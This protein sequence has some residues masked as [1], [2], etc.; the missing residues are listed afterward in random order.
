MGCDEHA[1]M[2][3]GERHWNIVRFGELHGAAEHNGGQ[4]IGVAAGW[5][6]VIRRQPGGDLHVDSD[7]GGAGRAANPGWRAVVAA[8]GRYVR[9]G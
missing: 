1:G 6:A 8:R 5:T 9:C 2:D 7:A 3:F 4:S